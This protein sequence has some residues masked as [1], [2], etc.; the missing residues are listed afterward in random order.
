MRVLFVSAWF[1][2]PPDN[3]SRI[4]AYNLIKAL[5]REHEVFLISLSRRTARRRGREKLAGICEVVSLT[6]QGGSGR[7]QRPVAQGSFAGR[8]P[9]CCTSILACG[10]PSGGCGGSDRG[11]RRSG[12]HQKTLGGGRVCAEGDSTFLMILEQHNCQVHGAQTPGETGDGGGAEAGRGVTRWD[13]RS[14][15][16][17]KQKRALMFDA[18]VIVCPRNHRVML[19]GSSEPG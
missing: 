8:G 9:R 18:V 12:L 15:P 17:G 16:D 7:A 2:C 6:S 5:S 4:R 3:G 19:R 1:P 14:S 11:T 10:R 13:G